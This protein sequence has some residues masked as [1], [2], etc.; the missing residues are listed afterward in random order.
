VSTKFDDSSNSRLRDMIGVPKIIM[1][2]WPD[3]APFS[4]WFIFV[5]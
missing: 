3:H 4:G 2:T 5:G 1:V